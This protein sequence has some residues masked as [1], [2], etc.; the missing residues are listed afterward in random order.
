MKTG[1]T[2]GDVSAPCANPAKHCCVLFLCSCWCLFCLAEQVK[3]KQDLI[4]TN[5]YIG[6]LFSVSATSEQIKGIIIIIIR[7]R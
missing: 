5:G 3:E 7:F 4:V 2:V 1:A 6:R